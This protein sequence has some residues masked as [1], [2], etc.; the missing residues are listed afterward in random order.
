MK[1]SNIVNDKLTAIQHGEALLLPVDKMPKGKTRKETKLIVAHSETGHHHVVEAKQEF[2]VIGNVEKEDLYFRL[3]E[4]AKLVHKK[5]VEKHKTLP[6][7]PGIW[8]VLHKTEYDPFNSLIRR[9]Q[10]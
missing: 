8:K 7:K 5:S 10:D 6:V 1:V 9:V 2:E 4:P 3:F